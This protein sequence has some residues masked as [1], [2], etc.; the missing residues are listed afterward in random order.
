MLNNHVEVA[1]NSNYWF[2]GSPWE[3]YP[4]IQALP[5]HYFT[6]PLTKQR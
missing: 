3:N 6:P 2:Q 4:T 1:I 5:Y